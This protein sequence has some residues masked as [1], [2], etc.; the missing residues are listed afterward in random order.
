VKGRERLLTLTY[1]RSILFAVQVA[2]SLRLS[3]MEDSAPSEIDV[4]LLTTH[5]VAPDGSVICLNIETAGGRPI[6]LR[7]P[8]F[9]VEQ[10]LMTLPHLLSK[11]LQARHGDVSLRAVFP[12]GDWR[13]EAAAGSKDYILTMSTS[14]GFEVAFALSAPTITRMMFA[15]EDQNSLTLKRPAILSS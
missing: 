15:M 4:G 8:S 12:L 10:L 9:C 3:N 2:L 6:T 11:A 13:L 14:D 1:V 5:Q 7:M